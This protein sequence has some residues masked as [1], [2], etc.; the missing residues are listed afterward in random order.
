M[1]KTE[2]SGIGLVLAV[3]ST[4]YLEIPKFQ[5]WIHKV[6]FCE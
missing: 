4:L 3:E 2:D 5:Y 1:G 6:V